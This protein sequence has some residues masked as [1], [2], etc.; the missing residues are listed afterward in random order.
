MPLNVLIVDQGL[1]FGGSIVSASNLIRSV[2]PNRFRFVFVSATDETLIRRKL[3]ERSD[4]TEVVIAR[5]KI[6]YKNSRRIFAGLRNS[7]RRS[8]QRLGVVLYSLTK[9]AGNLPYMLRIARCIRKYRIDLVQLNNGV[10]GEVGLVCRLLGVTPVSYL[11]GH[12]PISAP[13]RKVL[14]PAISRFFAVSA[15]I[16]QLAI[17][18]GVEASRISV[19]PPL[20]I[21]ETVSPASLSQ[22]RRRYDLA[23]GQATVGIFGRIVRWK[24]QK[25]FI[26]AAAIVAEHWDVKF[27][28]IG[29]TTDGEEAYWSQVLKTVE[30]L[31]LEDRIVFTGYVEKVYDYYA[32]MDVV[33]HASI[34]PEPFGR[35]VLEA[36]SEGKPV[37]ASTLGGPK[38][39]INDGENGLLVDP[40][41]KA[42]LAKRILEVIRNPQLAEG[43][44][45]AARKKIEQ[46]FSRQEY[47]KRME[48]LYLRA[49]QPDSERLQSPPLRKDRFQPR[50]END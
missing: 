9:L 43:L 30:D 2:D 38:E 7:R 47:G 24:G 35:V 6:N 42:L 41:D 32:L 4:D 40:M 8:L 15:Y 26:E 49:L 28:V 25:E 45:C 34:K 11:R 13:Q 1:D 46:F 20:A 48:A 5:K 3:R 12:V 22:L 19:A 14:L 37:I 10:D 31:G 18:D 17:R 50:R 27:F 29:E 36:M 44:G 21:R 16:R 23:Q 33:V 39:F